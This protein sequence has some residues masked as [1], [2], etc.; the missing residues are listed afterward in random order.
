MS[1]I[2][3]APEPRLEVISI[4]KR[5]PGVLALGD[6]S[7]RVMPGETLAVI[8]ENGA[9]KSTLMKILAGI[10]VPDDGQIRL[11]GQPVAFG[12]PADAL[13]SGISLIHQELSLHQHLSVAENLCL[14]RE[15]NRFGWIDRTAMRR[16]ATSYLH[17]VG[18]DVAP[19]TPVGALST[20]ACQL[21][22]IAK[23]LS[24]DAS[25][26][27]MDEPTSSLSTREADRLFELVE[28]M[29]ADGVSVIYISHRLGEVIRLADRV[30][31]LRDGR[32]A[33]ELIG[34]EIDHDL[35]V[36]AMVGRD[37]S[38]LFQRDPH[39]P[40]P[41][42]LR[43]TDLRVG[44]RAAAPVGL[45]V[46]R[47]EVVGIAGLVGAGRSELLETI[48]GVRRATAGEVVVDGKSVRRGS[49]REAIRSG[50]ALVPEDRKQ[51][52]L[53]LE[54]TV[55]ENATLPALVDAPAAPWVDR[56][57]Q[58]TATAEVIDRLGV[59]T[60]SQTSVIGN[61]SGGNQQKIAFGK[62]WLRR[63]KVLMLDEPTRGV[64]VG[65]KQEIYRLL[66][67]LAAEGLAILFVSSELE[68]VLALAD[69]V[70]V[71]HEGRI[72]GELTRAEM[73][74]EAIMRLAVGI[75]SCN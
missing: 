66:D 30:V 69:R 5:F 15:P 73:T 36:S 29:R 54:S 21:V 55:Q 74:E 42:C 8:G 40:G 18:L 61:L 22:E 51:T 56:R 46:A 32:N 43:V 26:V 70:I 9:G 57:W 13:G 50:L 31:V 62:W 1:R 7:L 45:S 72:R 10:E 38:Q 71:M 25:V 48:F 17:R 64:D 34:K 27:I 47:G 3:D 35:M 53:L 20:A 24:T 63:P 2:A 58:Q 65:A 67:R 4:S 33:G 6:V 68:E 14:G 11:R 60:A 23:A 12:S 52:G 28:G 75:E 39:P 41:I 44:S 37:I 16:S 49:V 59:K 19:E